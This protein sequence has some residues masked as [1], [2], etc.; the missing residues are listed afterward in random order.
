MNFMNIA[1]NCLMISS[2]V[3]GLNSELMTKTKYCFML[4]TSKWRNTIAFSF[5][6]CS[7]FLFLHRFRNEFARSL[8]NGKY[9]S[10]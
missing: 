6:I 7:C 5:C 8:T 10:S 4:E 2:Y 1:N 3:C 9:F